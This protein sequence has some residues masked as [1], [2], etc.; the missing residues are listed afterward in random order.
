MAKVEASQPGPQP[1]LF[2]VGTNQT[3]VLPG[4]CCFLKAPG[5]VSQLSIGSL[6]FALASLL[7]S[8]WSDEAGR[9]GISC[10]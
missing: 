2:G 4:S 10:A 3:V 8:W 5:A 1:Q 9:I 6:M 7:P